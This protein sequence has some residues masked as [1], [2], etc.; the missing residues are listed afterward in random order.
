MLC[1]TRHQG[2]AHPLHK[3]ISH[4]KQLVVP[5][6]GRFHA[7]FFVPVRLSKISGLWLGFGEEVDAFDTIFQ[8]R[9]APLFLPAAGNAKGG[10]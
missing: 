10:R 6:N 8:R 9:P 7:V 1:L 3:I 2:L 5:K 4:I